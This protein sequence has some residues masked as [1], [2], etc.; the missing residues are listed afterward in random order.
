MRKYNRRILTALVVAYK[1]GIINRKPL[2]KW[3]DFSHIFYRSMKYISYLILFSFIFLILDQ[4]IYNYFNL[5]QNVYIGGNIIQKSRIISGLIIGILAFNLYRLGKY[6]MEVYIVKKAMK[7]YKVTE[8]DV[9]KLNSVT[10][11]IH[12]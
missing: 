5:N 12:V 9:E 6:Y 8:N 1:K 7:E 11:K 4:K 2:N 10:F 3:L